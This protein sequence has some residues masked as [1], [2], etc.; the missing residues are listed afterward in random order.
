MKSQ[1]VLV[2]S[3]VAMLRATDLAQE[4]PS[5]QN[6]ELVNNITDVIALVIEGYHNM[7]NTSRQATN[8]IRQLNRRAFLATFL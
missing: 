5:K 1:I 4:D 3:I 8:L 6:R 7:N 2:L